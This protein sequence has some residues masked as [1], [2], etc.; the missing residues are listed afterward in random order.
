MIIYRGLGFARESYR[1]DAW[2]LVYTTA[3]NDGEVIA[4]T[5]RPAANVRDAMLD[6][7]N[8]F[9]TSTLS[10]RNGVWAPFDGVPWEIHEI[11]DETAYQAALIA[12]RLSTL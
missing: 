10:R 9:R 8:V 4:Y 2:W 11:V 6:W 3:G 12:Y 1:N 5:S 7:P